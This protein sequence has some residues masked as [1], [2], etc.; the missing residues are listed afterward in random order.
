VEYITAKDVAKL[1]NC[2]TKTIYSWAETQHEG[3]PA[4]KLGNGRKSLLRFK[5]DEIEQWIEKWK[6]RS[7]KQFKSL[8]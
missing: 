4:Y 1:L 5:P 2:S 8:L 7:E 3:F 6:L